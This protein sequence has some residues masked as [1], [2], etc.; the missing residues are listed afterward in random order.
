MP[1]IVQAGVVNLLSLDLDAAQQL[2]ENRGWPRYR[3]TQLLRWL[4][5]KRVRSIDQMT[6]FSQAERMNL[7]QCATILRT[8]VVQTLR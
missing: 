5:R 3:A 7:H 4:Y 2:I 1:S 8:E 6:D